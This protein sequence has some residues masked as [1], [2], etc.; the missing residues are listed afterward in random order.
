MKSLQSYFYRVGAWVGY[1]MPPEILL[2]CAVHFR[3]VARWRGADRPDDKLKAKNLI[4]LALEAGGDKHPH[5]DH[6]LRH[7]QANGD[8]DIVLL[9]NNWMEKRE[10]KKPSASPL[11]PA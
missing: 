11:Q 3:D 7:A 4:T 6:A 9:L 10:P 2:D 8:A 1:E 5:I